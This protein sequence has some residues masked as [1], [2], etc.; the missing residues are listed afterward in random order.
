MNTR[1]VRQRTITLVSPILAFAALAVAAETSGRG[2]A[3]ADSPAQ[4]ELKWKP[5]R[6]AT[7]AAQPAP[8]ATAAKDDTA[9]DDTAEPGRVAP[10]PLAAVAPPAEASPRPAPSGPPATVS[11]PP[12][13]PPIA[14]AARGP[15]SYAPLRGRPAGRLEDWSGPNRVPGGMRQAA[16]P[17]STW[18]MFNVDLVRAPQGDAPRPILAAEGRQAM[19]MQRVAGRVPGNGGTA[20]RLGGGLAPRFTPAGNGSRPERL[21]MKVD[22]IPSVMAQAPQVGAL[23]DAG[24]PGRIPPGAG[25]GAAT[26]PAKGNA[27]PLPTPATEGIG[28]PDT[29]FVE[30][31]PADYGPEGGEQFDPTM[32][33]DSGMSGP[34]GM[35]L[36]EYPPRMHVESFYDDPY[37]CEDDECSPCMHYHG[38]MCMWLRQFGKPYYGWHWYR[39]FTASAGVMGFT[40]DSNLGLNGNFGTNEYLNWAM[41]FW[42]AFGVGWQLG[43]RATQSGFQSTTLTTP[44]GRLQTS[45]RQQVFVTSGF[46]TRAFE[47]RGLQGGA[48]YD[49]LSDTWFDN[50]D[51]S[52]VRAELSY[53][54]GYHEFGVWTAN[55]VANQNSKSGT[56]LQR[57]TVGT[58]YDMYC[59]FYR[60]QFGDANE[61]KVWGGATGDGDGI[62][63]SLLR[64]PMSRSLALEGTF[65]YLIPKDSKTIDVD[66]AGTGLGYSPAAWNVGLNLVYYPAGR[67]RRSLASPYR[68]LFEVADNGSM[69]RQIDVAR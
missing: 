53:V 31:A 21:A 60:L 68:P 69:I 66:G 43:A 62:I 58:T 57:Q 40:N 1:T 54:W 17:K 11:L 8:E 67:S 61:W 3:T 14:E 56:P 47:G 18:D 51:V 15:N 42:N 22:G 16:A 19:A 28:L 24:V 55:N 39:D 7:A 26:A 2:R 12:D 41:P 4:T 35:M 32:M 23:D 63:G 10:A 59:G 5:H 44:G 52:Q 27:Q 20:D 34:D 6:A 13:V 29:T 65:T 25:A 37:E 64:A 46:F 45:D 30:S 49:Y 38:Q 33:S 48:V 50:V 36:G 9:A